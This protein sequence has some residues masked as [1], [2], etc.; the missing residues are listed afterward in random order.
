MT[1][2]NR[3]NKPAAPALKLDLGC[4]KN[5]KPGFLGVDCR[6]FEGVDVVADLSKGTWPWK[7][8]SVDEVHCSHFIEHLTA[9][10]R[11]HFVNELHRVLKPGAPAHVIVPHWNSH[12]AF[13]LL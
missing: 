3:K 10:E 8:G 9:A 5:K 12:R 6:K 11:I 4:G 7:D 1:K 2:R 13:G